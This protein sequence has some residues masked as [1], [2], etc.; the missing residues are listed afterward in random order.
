MLEISSRLGFW[1]PGS[2]ES[3]RERSLGV[4]SATVTK[5]SMPWVARI[6]ARAPFESDFC[7]SYED[8][9][10]PAWSSKVQHGFG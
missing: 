3:K 6:Q 8:L 9:D 1:D 7:D 10:A 5:K 2:P 4:I